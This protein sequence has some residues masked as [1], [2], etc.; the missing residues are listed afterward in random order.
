MSCHPMS[1]CRR[2]QRSVRSRFQKRPHAMPSIYSTVE[3]IV[4][5]T[6]NWWWWWWWWW[7]WSPNMTKYDKCKRKQ[8]SDLEMSL[9]LPGS[10]DGSSLL[11][12]S[13]PRQWNF[14]TF[15][16]RKALRGRTWGPL[17][18]GVKVEPNSKW[19]SYSLLDWDAHD[20]QTLELYMATCQQRLDLL[21][22]ASW[23]P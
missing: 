18:L 22:E 16:S 23:K 1:I 3:P 12:G 17:D 10:Y 21:M 13:G 9:A 6:V 8:N 5:C 14:N 15:V 2:Y 19:F 7:W 11:F 20:V 4:Q